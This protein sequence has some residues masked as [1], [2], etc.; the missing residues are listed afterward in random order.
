MR[1]DSNISL[2]AIRRVLEMICKERACKKKSLE[3]MLKDMVS[4]NIL[5]DTLD[6]CGVLIRKLGNS[7]AHGDE[8]NY[9]SRNDLE[10]LINFTETIIY[11]IYELPTKVDKLNRRY[12]SESNRSNDNNDVGIKDHNV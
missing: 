5:P 6:Q 7:G 3:A 11:Y 8:G 2:L 10:E 4:K 9:I 1:I 12:L